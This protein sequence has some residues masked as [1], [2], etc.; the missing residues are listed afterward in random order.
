VYKRQLLTQ[1]STKVYHVIAGAW[2]TLQGP[3]GNDVLT[4]ADLNSRTTWSD[5][6]KHTFVANDDFSPVMKLYV[7]GGDLKV[8]SAGLPKLANPPT[9]TKTVSDVANYIY[10]FVYFFEYSVGTVVYN[11]FGAVTQVALLNTAEPDIGVV[12]ITNIPVIANGVDNNWDTASIKIKIYRTQNNGNVGTYIGEVTNG[13]TIYNDSASDAS[14]INNAALY[15]VGG[16]VENDPTPL[17]RCL[18]V[19][20]TAG[21]Y[22]HIK[23]ASGEILSN[24]VRQSI[25]GDP[26]SC[27][28]SFFV[29]LDDSIVGISSAGQTP[30]VFCETSIYRL[31][32]LYDG[33]GGGLLEKQEIE[34]TVGC[35]SMNSIVQVQRGVVFAGETGFYFTDGWEVRKLSNNFNDTYK[36][37]TITSEQKE[38]IY[39]TFDRND[40]RVWWSIQETPTVEIPV[41]TEVNKCY[42]IDTRYGL[43][44]AQNDLETLQGVFTTI[45]NLEYFKPTAIIFKDGNLIRGDARGYTFEHKAEYSNDPLL[46][47]AL[48]PANWDVSAIPWD[49]KSVATSFGSSLKRKYCPKMTVTAEN[50]TNLTVQANSINDIGRNIRS[51]KP[52]RSRKNW[53]WD[54]PSITWG[55][56]T[57]IWDF[58]GLIEEERRFFSD[59]LRCSYK[60]IQ[61]T[62]AFDVIINSDDLIASTNDVVLKTSTLDSSITIGD[63]ADP[64]LAPINGDRYFIIAPATGA[65]TGLEGQVAT[66]DTVAGVWTYT[67][68]FNW[69]VDCRGQYIYFEDDNY[70]VGFLITART[71][72]VITYAD[73]TNST[74]PGSKKWVI[75]GVAKTE[76]LD[77]ISYS[78]WYAYLG[79]PID[80][81]ARS[82]GGTPA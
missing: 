38:R 64:P 81:S 3:T 53:V 61:I 39:G 9:V 34:S 12:N 29:D 51:M 72:N 68:D 65:W 33:Q 6:N 71:D 26:D 58:M 78:L 21:F 46:E 66:W 16:Q 4:T 62:N 80:F 11:D 60:Q 2:A 42:V 8:R 13:T 23:T 73:S 54:D 52:I 69:P 17:C 67:A 37:F 32:G 22:G 77:L 44:E 45:S 47:T 75:R 7:D 70:S 36:S 76:V 57:Q 5:W 56:E 30:I 49:Y 50:N 63:L 20:D 15:T 40:K 27:P 18:H 35:I 41:I 59:S 55:D 28:E 82:A 43:G 25:P 79:G 48:A 19:T 24:R 1:S 74:V 31:D 10:Y 14:I